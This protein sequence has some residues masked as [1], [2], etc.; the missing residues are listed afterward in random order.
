[1][2]D[3]MFFFFRNQLHLIEAQLFLKFMPFGARSLSF[4]LKMSLHSEKIENTVLSVDGRGLRRDVRFAVK[5]EVWSVRGS[6][7][8][9]HNYSGKQPVTN[10]LIATEHEHN[11]ILTAK[12]RWYRVGFLAILNNNVDPIYSHSAM[13]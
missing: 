3:Q 7:S 1:M 5:H 12:R 13:Q 8:C 10:K 4:M 2:L 11:C 9:L 6:K